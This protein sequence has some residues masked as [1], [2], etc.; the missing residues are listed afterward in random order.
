LLHSIQKQTYRRIETIIVDNRSSDSTSDLAKKFGVQVISAGPERSAQRNLGAE[1]SR[2]DLFLFL[3]ADM[4]MTPNVVEACVS[5]IERG[6]DALCILERP[7]GNG[8][9]SR[10]RALELSGYF[11]SE[12]FEAARCFQRNTFEALGGYNPAM[13]G[14]EDLDIQARLVEA[15]YRL[16]WVKT[17]ILHHEE[18][19]GLGNYLRKRR[20]YGKT[21]RVYANRHPD[22]WRRQRSMKERWL[23]LAP[24]VHSLQA[25][26]LLPGLI[27]LRGVE[28]FLRR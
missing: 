28:W 10:A 6:V 13:T 20:Y 1:K 7:V 23:Y 11:G 19:L 5:G 17:P 21:D 27:F 18:R 26:E 12:L 3:D 14:L 25:L 22:R 8:Y 4:E 15:Q 9:W 24:R 2:G 16:G